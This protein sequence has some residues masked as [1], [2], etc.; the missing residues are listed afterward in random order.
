MKRLTA[1]A[2][3]L[4]VLPWAAAGQA[5]SPEVVWQFK[6][7]RVSVRSVGG[8]RGAAVRRVRLAP[9]SDVPLGRRKLAPRP[10]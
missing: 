6:Q 2:M 4:L 10:R 1:V 3:L 7:R 5:S 9:V 8:R